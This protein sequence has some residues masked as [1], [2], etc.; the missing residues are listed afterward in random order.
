MSSGGSGNAVEAGIADS[1][2]ALGRTAQTFRSRY[3][4]RSGSIDVSGMGTPRGSMSI[5]GSGVGGCGVIPASKK[6]VKFAVDVEAS[7][8]T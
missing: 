2:M 3:L 1:T 5:A 6:G 8:D 7:S 4:K